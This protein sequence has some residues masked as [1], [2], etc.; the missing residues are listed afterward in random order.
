MSMSTHNGLYSVPFAIHGNEDGVMVYAHDSGQRY[1]W[2]YAPQGAVSSC[3]EWLQDANRGY[4]P[5]QCV[6]T[7]DLIPLSWISEADEYVG[8]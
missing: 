5:Q 4:F 1:H 7:V 8:S 2:S 3:H 6:G